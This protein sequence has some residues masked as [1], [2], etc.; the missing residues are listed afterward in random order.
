MRPVSGADMSSQC[1]FDEALPRAVRLVT[2]RFPGDR[3]RPGA[4]HSRHEWPDASSWCRMRSRITHWLRR[5][6]R[7]RRRSESTAQ[8]WTVAWCASR[9]T[10]SGSALLRGAG[11][12][13]VRRWASRTTD[14]AAGDRAGLGAGT[15]AGTR[16]GAS[17]AG[18]ILQ[19]KGRSRAEYRVVLLGT[20]SGRTGQDRAAGGPGSGGARSG[21]AAAAGRGP[22]GLWRA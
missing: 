14:R 7:W 20:P 21:G 5:G 13:S 4:V 18:G 22:S 2:E 17:A 11:A 3:H 10:L 19:S 8:V 1:T 15:G 12:D 9:E 6:P 16:G